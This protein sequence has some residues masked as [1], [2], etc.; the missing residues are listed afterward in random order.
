MRIELE[1]VSKRYGRQ[2][3]LS[4]VSLDLPEGARVALVGPNGS[5]KSTLIKILMGLLGYD[6]VVR[7]GGL[8]RRRAGA[9]IAR[10]LAYV[11][12]VAPLAA[13]SV[14]ELCAAV[15]QVRGI[16]GARVARNAAGLELDLAAIRRKPFRALSGGMRQK[17]LLALAL[18][19]DAS[20]SVLDEPTASLDARGRAAFL[21]LYEEI[22]PGA[23][24][25]LCSHR[26]EEI[27]HLVDHVVLLEDG[28]V[29]FDGTADGFLA[30]RAASIVE[31]LV[32]V[33]AGEPWLRDQGFTEG[34]GGWWA[35]MATP[36]EKVKL[37]PDASQ[38]L[39]G[40]LRDVVVRDV[41]SLDP[42]ARPDA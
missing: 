38:A 19:A 32:E 42:G 6:G 10:R 41:E 9:Q 3:A 13:A 4:G 21:R 33:G 30:G 5:G 23:T 37:L 35:R 2:P 22:A 1:D 11:P 7:I 20:L 26:L 31:L 24:L 12:Q 16:A 34:A 27:R 15:T 8:D 17:V 36:A 18:A 14:G 39:G 40:A 29:A 25:L 28:R